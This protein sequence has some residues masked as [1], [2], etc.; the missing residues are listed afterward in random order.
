MIGQPPARLRKRNA[1]PLFGEREPVITPKGPGIVANVLPAPARRGVI[2]AVRLARRK[3]QPEPRTRIFY[4]VELKPA[5]QSKRLE[6][7][8]EG[9]R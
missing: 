2:Y 3:F 5:G 4:Q 6:S 1:Q 9:Q 7:P 8:Q